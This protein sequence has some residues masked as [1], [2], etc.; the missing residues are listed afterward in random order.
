MIANLVLPDALRRQLADEAHAAFPRECC[1]L[2]EGERRGDTAVAIVLH[3]TRNLAQAHDRFEIDPVDHFRLLRA[4]RGT[5]REIV[6]CYHSHPN[7]RAEPS[8]RDA[9]GAGEEDF[10]WLI[11]AILDGDA[12]VTIS[13][14][15]SCRG[16]FVP[17]NLT[18]A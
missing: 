6:G 9:D 12:S 11:A 15:A 7:G 17:L 14:F 13:A 3:A 5:G 2:I 10:V 4:L 16:A 18:C 1:G 8:A